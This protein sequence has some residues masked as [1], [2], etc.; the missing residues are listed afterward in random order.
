M[1]YVL[2]TNSQNLRRNHLVLKQPSPFPQILQK[3]KEKFHL[4]VH[5]LIIFNKKADHDKNIY[6][7]K[8]PSF[9]QEYF[10]K[11][12]NDKGDEIR[13]CKILDE[14]GKKCDQEYK[15]VG[16]STENL[17]VHLRD[18]DEIVMQDDT[19]VLKKV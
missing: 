18:K 2:C 11:S 14:S 3:T 17:I 10:E 1:S 15:N 12:I 5:L 6:K 19:A 13:I 8:K 16:S 7:R 4:Y 9:T